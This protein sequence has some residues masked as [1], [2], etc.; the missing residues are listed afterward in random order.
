[1]SLQ[2]VRGW[3]CIV[4]RVYECVYQSADVMM[5]FLFY[6][7]RSLTSSRTSSQWSDSTK[8]SSGCT[9]RSSRMKTTQ[10]TLWVPDTTLHT[11]T[12][13]EY[14]EYNLNL[15]IKKTKFLVLEIN[16]KLMAVLT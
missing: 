9:T 16:K 10:D 3:L 8:S 2:T 11:P 13:P 5:Y 7:A 6:R 12:V 14:K 1:M 15:N 4:D